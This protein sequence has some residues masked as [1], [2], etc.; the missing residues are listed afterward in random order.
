[1]SSKP[2]IFDSAGQFGHRVRE[3]RLELGLSQEALADLAHLHWTYVGSI[4]R[5]QRNVALLN[6]LKLAHGLDID[7]AVLVTGLLP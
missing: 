7:A 3:R 1:M 4:E 2:P 5:G 6:I